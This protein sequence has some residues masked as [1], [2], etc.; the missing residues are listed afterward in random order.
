MRYSIKKLRYSWLVFNVNTGR[1]I[2]TLATKAQATKVAMVLNE[3][4]KQGRK[5]YGIQVNQ[6]TG[7]VNSTVLHP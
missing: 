4:S 6:V 5:G 7:I 3:A 2:G 1:M